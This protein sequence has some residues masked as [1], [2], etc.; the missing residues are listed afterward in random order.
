MQTAAAI[1]EISDGILGRPPI[2]NETGQF[3]PIAFA[4]MRRPLALWR[5]QTQSLQQ[6]EKLLLG[7]DQHSTLPAPGIRITSSW[8]GFR[9]GNQET[10]RQ[11]EVTSK[12]V[13]NT[14][15]KRDEA[16]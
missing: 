14:G 5:Q 13:V 10:S 3:G 1:P 6:I 8:C 7:I 9:A 2:R 15:Y 12:A 16:C 4:Y 11:N